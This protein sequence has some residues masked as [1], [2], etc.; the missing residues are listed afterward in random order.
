MRERDW[1]TVAWLT[2]AI[3]LSIAF[4]TA[5]G[6]YVGRGRYDCFPLDLEPNPKMARDVI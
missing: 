2:L 6:W 5:V 1:A 3:V 4:A